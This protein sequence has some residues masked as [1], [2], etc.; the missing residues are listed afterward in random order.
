MSKAKLQAARE[1]ILGEQYEA[2]RAI[3]STMKAS[4]TAQK[5]LA[6]IDEIAPAEGEIMQ[7]WEYQ[8]IFVKAADQLPQDVAQVIDDHH[9]TTVDH[10]YTRLLN[11]Y[12]AEGWELI[13]EA[14]HGGDV[15]R[16]L[17]KR[18]MQNGSVH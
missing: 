16:L 18:P 9:F 6:K 11:E 14:Q 17:F 8:E 7:P 12:G 4:P 15:V 1:F 10:F 3:L 13:S 2:A 5:W